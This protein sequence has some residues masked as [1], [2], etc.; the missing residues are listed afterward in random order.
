[1][2]RPMIV[3]ALVLLVPL[4]CGGAAAPVPAVGPRPPAVL[5][6]RS[7]REPLRPGP[8]AQAAAGSV[9]VSIPVVFRVDVLSQV[10]TSGRC[11][12]VVAVTDGRPAR[13]GFTV[14]AAGGGRG[15]LDAAQVPGNAM[16]ATDVRVQGPTA[17]YP[18]GLGIGSVRLTGTFDS[19][20]R[21][22]LR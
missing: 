20:P 13:P 16:R 10:T 8:G 11:A 15:A 21:W 14:V 7:D 5:A 6:V 3:P 1:M 17:R 12:V 19:C 18:A 9:A 2:P 22:S 4:L